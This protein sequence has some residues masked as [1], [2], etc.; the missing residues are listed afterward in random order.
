MHN[1]R[2]RFNPRKLAFIIWMAFPKL[3]LKI[4]GK[5]FLTCNNRSSFNSKALMAN[6]HPSSA[7]VDRESTHFPSRVIFDLIFPDSSSHCTWQMVIAAFINVSPPSLHSLI[8]SIQVS[9]RIFNFGSQCLCSSTRYQ[10]VGRRA[11]F[12]YRAWY[13][14]IEFPDCHTEESS[15]A[16]VLMCS[17]KTIW[18]HTV[19]YNRTQHNFLCFT[20]FRTWSH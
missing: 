9:T 1:S 10:N 12:S 7:L 8:D 15:K 2:T 11:L 16:K 19:L 3:K 6:L 5:K 17:L 14:F 4:H 20:C 13:D 18:C